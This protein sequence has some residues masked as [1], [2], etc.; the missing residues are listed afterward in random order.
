MRNHVT[1]LIAQNVLFSCIF[2]LCSKTVFGHNSFNST[3]PENMFH[4]GRCSD[5]TS[6][7]DNGLKAKCKKNIATKI[8]NNKK[9]VKKYGSIFNV[10]RAVA[11]KEVCFLRFAIYF[12]IIYNDFE[13]VR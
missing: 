2:T 12:E 3:W 13:K 9:Y 4:I 7:I 8:N 5:T 10:I 1:T 6:V 11:L